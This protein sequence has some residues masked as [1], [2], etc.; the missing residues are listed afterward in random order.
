MVERL[1]AYVREVTT[2]LNP[3]DNVVLEICD[4]PYI[5]GTPP[6][7]AGQWIADMLKVILRTESGL[8]K[9][10]LVAQQVEG[11][12]G[13][14]DF[15]SNPGITLI[16]GQYVWNTTGDQVGGMRLLDLKYDCNKPIEMN[17]TSYYPVWYKGD[18]VGDS[19]V[20]AW[21][22]IVGG[23]AGFNQLNGRFTAKDPA[24]STPDNQE[25]LAALRNLNDFMQ[26][27]D[28]LKMKPDR[29]MLVGEM[30]EH[31]YWRAISEPGKQ[32]AIYMHHSTGA[33]QGDH[34]AQLQAYRVLPD[35]Y[36]HDLVLRLPAGIY[37]VQWIEPATGKVMRTD[38]LAS[39]G[40]DQTLAT[41]QYAVDIAVRIK[42][43]E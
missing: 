24:G 3:F 13:P 22:F 34:K 15:A 20:E 11:L 35:E 23:G 39:T 41:P 10:H 37:R 16:T 40:D 38:R 19:R 7:L 28:F 14:C 21:E 42:R 31:T 18:K 27:F 26:S 8:P 4:E 32:Y 33:K 25:V 29:S 9:R 12:D 1:E 36:Q 5:N 17:E 30:P 6:E 43:A 2:A